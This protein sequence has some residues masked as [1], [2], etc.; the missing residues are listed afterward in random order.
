MLK[1]YKKRGFTIIEVMVVVAII[2]ILVGIV[3][4]AGDAAKKTTRDNQRR[5]DISLLQIKL[6]AYRADNGGLYPTSLDQLTTPNSLGNV[7]I[8]AATMPKD[9]LSKA[10]YMY[11]PLQLGT[12]S[13]TCGMSYYL[14]A[15]LENNNPK[16]D[17]DFVNELSNSNPS[18]K[19]C[20]TTDYVS[21]P[22]TPPRGSQ[23]YE[24]VSPEVSQAQPKTI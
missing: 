1:Q 10:E 7:Y 9:P 11:D 6:E 20:G 3:I 18:F 24:V 17:I 23:T 21:T 13:A 14:R 5:T 12:N 22:T 15:D 19:S 8:T 16:Y 2:G 4:A